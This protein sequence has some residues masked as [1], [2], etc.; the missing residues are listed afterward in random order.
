MSANLN[1]GYFLGN[2]S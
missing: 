2:Q 1:L